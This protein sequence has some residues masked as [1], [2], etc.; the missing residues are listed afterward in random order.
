M[1][2]SV[3]AE[4][5]TSQVR[6]LI[7]AALA[8]FLLVPSG[9]AASQLQPLK[10]IE[11]ITFVTGLHPTS[12]LAGFPARDY[13]GLAG[14][15]VG[16]LVRAPFS[17][18]VPRNRPWGWLP[19]QSPNEG[20]GGAR[21]YL[22]RTKTGQTA[23]LS[24]LGNPS[25]GGIFLKPGECF[26]QGDPVGHLW[27]WPGNPGRT[28]TH[29]GYQGGDPLY[30]LVD[31]AGRFRIQEG[32]VWTPQE[33]VFPRPVL[34]HEGQ[35]WRVQVGQKR[36]YQGGEEKARQ[37]YNVQKLARTINLHFK[38]KYKQSPLVGWG[39]PMVRIARRYDV[40][41]RLLAAIASCETTGGT[42]GGGPQVNN[43]FGLLLPNGEHRP[44]KSRKQAILYISKLLHD[45]YVGKGL[46]TIE[47]I[48]AKYAPTSARNDPHGKNHHWVNCVTGVYK[49]LHGTRFI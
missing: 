7:L 11:R 26:R 44:F 19:Y 22:T 28:H 10:F 33:Q 12:G 42:R 27:S 34:R 8:A 29:M 25:Y 17:G 40:D 21:V 9:F 47:K 16:A 30:T 18:C 43:D 41:P 2:R 46:N 48:G 3:N 36:L 14:N 6:R 13:G 49:A 45:K 15:P 39:L 35:W 37:V 1:A 5:L 24:H 32:P 20:F 23:Y 38:T 4:V 31:T